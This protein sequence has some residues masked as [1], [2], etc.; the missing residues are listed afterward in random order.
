MISWV[1]PDTGLIE[2]FNLELPITDEALTAA[3]DRDDL[4]P[5]NRLLDALADPYDYTRDRHGLLDGPGPHDPAY[6]TFCG[7]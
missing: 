1:L 4:E 6:R 7:T 2:D 3:A 5:V